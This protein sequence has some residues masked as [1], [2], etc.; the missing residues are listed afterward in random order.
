MLAARCTATTFHLYA[1]SIPLH[2]ACIGLS[3]PVS[4]PTSPFP[5]VL[6]SQPP[7]FYRGSACTC[8]CVPVPIR[9]NY[10]VLDVR[11][12]SSSSSGF[13][14]TALSSFRDHRLSGGV[15]GGVGTSPQP[16]LIHRF[17]SAA[18]R[19]IGLR[20]TCLSVELGATR[21]D[22]TQSRPR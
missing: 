18:F 10:E 12:F 1:F 3:R 5:M 13:V 22:T 7:Y 8:L 11:R 9:G 4:Q 2:P 19:A 20:D 14:S 6:P 15:Q 17:L 21:S 16:C